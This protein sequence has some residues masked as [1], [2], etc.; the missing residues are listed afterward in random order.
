MSAFF[1]SP[2]FDIEKEFVKSG[3]R[4]IAGVDEAGRGCLAGP[5][6]LGLVIY[7]ESMFKRNHEDIMN[8][9]NDSKKMTPRQRQRAFALIKSTCLF[10]D[11]IMV[12][13]QT[14]DTLNINRAT[15]FALNKLLR[16]IPVKPDIVLLDG[17]FS[18]SVPVPCVSVK[19]GDARSLSIAS[20]SVLAKVTRDG[21]METFDGIYPGFGFAR[22]KGYGT[23]QH[24]E[25]I[26]KMG[27]CTIHRKSYEPVK[28]IC[29]EESEGTS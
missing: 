22:N 24:R 26:K 12:S 23:L 28:S 2:S 13:H 8:I 19:K 3:H 20:A 10:A 18:F 27:Y 15:E 6:A 21:I 7:H 4:L 16:G 17:N 9:V 14:V 1:D 11:V 25:A 5:L 29:M